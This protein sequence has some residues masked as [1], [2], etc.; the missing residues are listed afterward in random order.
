MNTKRLFLIG[1][2]LSALVVISFIFFDSRK[3]K[4]NSAGLSTENTNETSTAIVNDL[5]ERQIDSDKLLQ[6]YRCDDLKDCPDDVFL[7]GSAEEARW[8]YRYGYPDTN[9]HRAFEKMTLEQL[10]SAAQTGS[11]VKIALYAK[12]LAESG[13]HQKA[14]ELLYRSI[15]Q[16]SLYALYV[17]SEVKEMPGEQQNMLQSAAALKLAYLLGDAKA[18]MAMSRHNGNLKASDLLAVDREADR[19]YAQIDQELAIRKLSL[20]LIF[21]QRRPQ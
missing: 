21:Q 1:F 20:R 2:F 13:D 12:K 15:E 14:S 7:A 17:L 10:A 6:A 11:K 5:D 18:S 4:V 16:G 3:V 19:M 8:L 9:A